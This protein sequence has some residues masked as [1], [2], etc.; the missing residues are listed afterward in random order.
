VQWRWA[1]L[2]ATNHPVLITG[3]DGPDELESSTGDRHFGFVDSC[4]AFF[5]KKAARKADDVMYVRVALT[6]EYLPETSNQE[7]L[8]DDLGEVQR[9]SGGGSNMHPAKFADAVCVVDAEQCATV[10]FE[11][12]RGI[13]PSFGEVVAIRDVASIG[14]LFLP[15]V[16]S[17]SG[18]L[19]VA[20][21]ELL[22]LRDLTCN[23][24]AREGSE[25]LLVSGVAKRS[26]LEKLEDSSDVMMVNEIGVD[27][28][29]T[30]I[31]LERAHVV[32]TQVDTSV[33]RVKDNKAPVFEDFDVGASGGRDNHEV[34][35]VGKDSTAHKHKMRRSDEGLAA[36][37]ET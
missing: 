24:C 34:V 20:N 9:V 28:E 3:L 15:E 17:Y 13:L 5:F 12:G 16:P 10:T 1:D 2:G 7:F 6:L 8:S 25:N 14:L 19:V 11:G 21:D 33:V 4:A 35:S 26:R 23:V 22:R 29:M 27:D 31:V 37:E 36:E 18:R 30:N 32:G